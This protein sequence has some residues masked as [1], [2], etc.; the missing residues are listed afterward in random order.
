MQIENS[1]TWTETCSEWV[2]SLSS[3]QPFRRASVPFVAEYWCPL[4]E[5]KPR[6]TQSNMHVTDDACTRKR[7]SYHRPSTKAAAMIFDGEKLQKPFGRC[8]LAHEKGNEVNCG[9][10]GNIKCLSKIDRIWFRCCHCSQFSPFSTWS[11][12]IWK[13]SAVQFWLHYADAIHPWYTSSCSKLIKYGQ[14]QT[15]WLPVSETK[16]KREA[17]WT[18]SRTVISTFESWF[19]IQSSHAQANSWE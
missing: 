4:T 14:L 7:C 15:L 6:Q 11:P 18:P 10:R 16:F 8:L 9:V 17:G 2:R 13:H 19:G 3:N 5:D 1:V 12:S